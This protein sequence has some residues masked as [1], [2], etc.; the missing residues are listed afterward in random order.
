MLSRTVDKKEIDT[1]S[2]SQKNITKVCDEIWH[3]TDYGICLDR[4]Y[5][6]P[7]YQDVKWIWKIIF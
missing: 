3:K 6:M 2:K 4:D 7:K 1:G 5:F